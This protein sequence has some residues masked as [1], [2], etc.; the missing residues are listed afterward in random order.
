MGYPMATRVQCDVCN[1]EVLVVQPGSGTLRC[2]D[3][4]MTVEASKGGNIT[5][6]EEED[7]GE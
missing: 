7:G 2:C 5:K 3:A 4:E 1:A 6:D